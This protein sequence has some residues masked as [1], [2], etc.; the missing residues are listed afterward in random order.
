MVAAVLLVWALVLASGSASRGSGTAL[1]RAGLV[2]PNLTSFLASTALLLAIAAPVEA[3]IG[4][5]RF[6]AAAVLTQLGGVLI[7]CLGAPVLVSD[8]PW[9]SGTFVSSELGPTTW[10]IGT[11]LCATAAMGGTWRRRLRLG[12]GAPLVA[13]V[14]VDGSP[15][16]V[17]LL[18]SA[19]TGILLGPWLVSRPTS[20]ADAPGSV[21][22]ARDLVR[23]HG[24]GTLSWMSTW[25]GNRYWFGAD[26]SSCV[27]YRVVL[28]VAL[29]TGDPVCPPERL[30][31][32]VTAFAE[33]CRGNGWTSCFYS[34]TDS[35]RVVTGNLGWT[36]IQVAEE[37]VVNLEDLAFRGK[38]YQDIRT[39]MNRAAKA[40][41][42]A[43][44]VSYPAAPC[45]VTDQIGTISKQWVADKGIPEM[46]FTLGG[47]EEL[48]D[49]DVRCLIAV[50]EDRTV[51]GF[52]SWLPVHHNG[53]V[54][55]WTL[56]LMRR[57]TGGFRPTMEFLIASAALFF[58]EE[59]VRFM[60]LSG[61]PLAQVE[62]DD[63]PEAGALDRLLEAL[64]NRLEPVYGFRSLLA[65]KAKFQPEYQPMYMTFADPTTL[66]SI[67]IALT[68]AYLPGLT[69][70]QT[71]RLVYKIIRR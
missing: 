44:W 16:H 22:A 66:P 49:P 57:R 46:G 40:G 43:E 35:V 2:A 6:V 9:E 59:G 70:L 7:S 10:I 21:A 52:T 67:G 37:A 36:S 12:L 24:R 32:T 28:G 30:H 63:T 51:H 42:S 3:R 17:A 31:H 55:G 45:D 1:V 33:H 71:I 19:V 62:H 65:F 50:D 68:R 53:V 58:A 27:A 47:L 29:T 41:I 26:G 25:R 56:D 13:L 5:V 14:I 18:G 20:T 60:S 38:R 48:N 61:A 39:A 34:V 11:L 23:K 15:H 8:R 69:A 54:V 64:G 4:W